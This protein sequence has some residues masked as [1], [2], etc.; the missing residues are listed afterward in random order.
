MRTI[1]LPEV[2]EVQVQTLVQF[3]NVADDYTVEWAD[4]K[5]RND[6]PVYEGLQSFGGHFK[7]VHQWI[8][9][10]CASVH[11]DQFAFTCQNEEQS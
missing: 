8:C 7:V 6:R 9:P 11:G 4:L 1:T 3:V 5:V 2:G 10:T